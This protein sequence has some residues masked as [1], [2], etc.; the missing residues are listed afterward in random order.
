[1]FSNLSIFHKLLIA[2]LIAV[3]LFAFYIGNIYM[4][5]IEGKKLMDSIYKEHFPIL[6]L[7][8]ENIILL[9][10]IIRVFEDSVAASEITWL[11]NNKI[12]KENIEKNFETLKEMG[13][14]KQ[15]LNTL[16]K[17][18]N[19][20]YSSAMNLSKIMIQSSNDWIRMEDLSK[21]MSFYLTK[22]K[23]EF[24]HFKIL[25]NEEL[26]QTITKT[27][28]YGERLV[29]FGIVLGLLS[30]ALI[31]ILT[32]FLSITTKKSLKELISSVKNITSG[33]PD[34]TKRLEKNSDDE[35][36]EL[37]EEFNNFTKKLQ[38]DYEELAQAKAQAE[39]A[40]QM[41]SEF[42]ANMSHEIRTPLNSI[43]GFSELL[44]KTEVSRKQKSYLESIS[45]GGNTLLA[46]INDIL[47]ISKIE[48]GKLEI[49]YEEV[50]LK[51]VLNDVKRIFI[52]N[53]KDK[54]LDFKV[55]FDST[56]PSLVLIDEIRLRQILLNIIGNAVK[57]THKGFIHI[58][59]KALDIKDD[60]FNLQIDVKD[61][62]IGIPK[63]EQEK[64]FESFVQQNGQRNR[65][66]GGTGLGLSICLKLVNMMN[67]SILLESVE[68][69]GSIFSII[70]NDL[71]IAENKSFEL[72]TLEYEEPNIKENSILRVDEEIKKELVDSI[73][74][75]W[76]KASQA[77]SSEDILEFSNILNEFAKINEQKE[78]MDFSIILNESVEKFDISTMENLIKVFSS[79]FKEINGD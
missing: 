31:L 36:G 45:L 8:S 18:F 30:L 66:Y 1:M 11:E 37:I 9:N 35:V 51:N 25:H 6:N 63:V 65:E 57:F 58:N 38:I 61:S 16:E 13:I 46:I 40:N 3:M 26:E 4:Q 15:N 27:N 73:K 59:I 5:Q 62:G 56:L 60:K 47:D 14:D 52:Q 20:Y 32:I 67:G 2:P 77:C 49:Q 72:K 23:D 70:L 48:A 78:L 12:Y 55:T 42:V 76:E 10:N 24:E 53:I 22:T 34:F 19:N 69:I 68:G 28:E 44:S 54:G 41:K 33:N 50:N 29:Y 39:T 64:I 74:N 21:E 17:S 43:I 79:F 71:A 75:S 7:A